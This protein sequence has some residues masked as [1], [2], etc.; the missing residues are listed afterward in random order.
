M[1]R[2]R[3]IVWLTA[4]VAALGACGQ[5]IEAPGVTATVATVSAVASPCDVALSADAAAGDPGLQ[6][7]QALVRS[8]SEKLAHLERLGWAYVSAARRGGD[9]GFYN[10]AL[11]SA[12]CLDEVAADPVEGLLLRAHVLQQ[13]HRFRD[14]EQA[15]RELVA[16]RGNWMDQAVLGDALLDQGQLEGAV[17]AYQ[18]MAD[19]RPGPDAYA[20]IAQVRWLTGDLPGATE[21]MTRAA[22]G[23]DSRDP[24]GTAWYRARLAQIVLASGDADAAL[25]LARASTALVPTP[26]GLATEGRV[27]LALGRNAEAVIVLEKAADRSGL[28]E[29]QWLLAEALDAVGERERVAAVEARLRKTGEAT[30]PRTYALFLATRGVTSGTTGSRDIATALRLA[31]E[32]LNRRADVYTED[33]LA[34]SMFVAGDASGALEHAQRAVAL[35]TPD[36]RLWLHACL[37]AARNGQFRSARTWLARARA[38][39]ALLLPSERQWLRTATTTSSPT[40]RSTDT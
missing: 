11:A 21:F 4:A 20:R 38:S 18:V 34:W 17:A 32:E 26:A 3:Q 36:A 6:K 23:T 13:Q 30:D 29:H 27:L 9:A 2:I 39:E 33:A 31:H 25:A 37:I 16:R 28:A 22:R 5:R 24:V 14:A 19:E 10:L 7:L 12:D 35:G 1:A 40:T 15:A 8:R